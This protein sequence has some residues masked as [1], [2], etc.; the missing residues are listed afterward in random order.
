MHIFY[1]YSTK[2]G[3]HSTPKRPLILDIS[4]SILS[5]I[6]FS[7]PPPHLIHSSTSFHPCL[8]TLFPFPK[9]FYLFPLVIEL[10]VYYYIHQHLPI[11]L[12]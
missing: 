5:H 8:S 4:R 1:E 10:L 12:S 2:L 11:S 6:P 9:E 7:F 3:Y